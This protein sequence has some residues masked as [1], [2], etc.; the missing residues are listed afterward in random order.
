MKIGHS[1]V[2]IYLTVLLGACGGGG[3][4]TSSSA[5]SNNTAPVANA[6]SNQNIV[7][8]TLVTLDGSTSTD[9]NS[10]SLTYLWTLTVKP[11]GSLAVLSSASAVKPTFIADIVGT[12]SA[13]LVVNDGKVSSVAATIIV[14]AAV[15]N[16]HPIANA[17]IAQNVITASTVTLNGSA[18]SDANGDQL[19]YVWTLTSK[20]TG[21][22]AVLAG[23]TGAMPVFAP[24][25]VGTY[26]ASLVVNDGKVNSTASTVTITASATNAAPVANAGTAQNVVAGSMV[27]LS[28]AASTDANRDTLMYAWTLTSKPTGSAAVLANATAIAPT[29][30]ADKTGT[31]VV[32]LVVNDGKLNSSAATITVSVA[33]GKIPDS[34]ITASQ[35]YAAGSDTLVSCTSAA[36]LALNDKQDGMVGLDVSSPTSSDGKLGFS[37]TKLDASGNVLPASAATWVCVKDNIT[38]L[39][40]EIKT[41]DGGLRYKYKTYTNYGDNRS[42]DASE[43]AAAVNATNL[44]GH[45]DWRVPTIL[46]LQGIVDYSKDHSL[47]DGPAIDS[48]WFINS[49]SENYWSSTALAGDASQAWNVDFRC[50]VVGY[51]G[52]NALYAVRLVR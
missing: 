36:A 18:S 11:T 41:N 43:F 23:A 48:A 46:E 50:G 51:C 40:W 1:M 47:G 33:S 5:P 25:I 12:Y 16:A 10:D 17:G 24:D 44:C 49:I 30:V 42:G 35:C 28:G 3:G 29:F 20:P 13:T 6:G 27:M 21:S 2:G 4:N 26:V 14:T 38:G 34:G 52:R 19:T 7:S 15:T 32:T 37:Y 9:E 8:G 31:Y 45:A 39:T 22:S